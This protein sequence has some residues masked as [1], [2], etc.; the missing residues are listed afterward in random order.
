[1]KK[2]GDLKL[3]G[4]SEFTRTA[5]TLV[6]ISIIIIVFLRILKIEDGLIEIL[7]WISF[8]TCAIFSALGG[9]FA[10]VWVISGSI[11]WKKNDL[12]IFS[13]LKNQNFLRYVVTWGLTSAFVGGIVGLMIFPGIV[14]LYGLVV[15]VFPI[16]AF[17]FLYFIFLMFPFG[18]LIVS[19]ATGFIIV[20]A[21]EKVILK[22]IPRQS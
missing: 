22:E 14:V 16:L 4:I 5:I 6:S 19:F 8:G 9:M 13:N 12:E 1:M 10:S 21:I 15:P 11:K 7:S 20:I 18:F 17:V 3:R 2:I